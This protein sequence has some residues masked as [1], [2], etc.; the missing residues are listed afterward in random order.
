MYGQYIFEKTE[1]VRMEL[2]YYCRLWTALQRMLHR[3]WVRID[4]VFGTCSRRQAW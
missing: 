1:S 2:C 3:G 4:D